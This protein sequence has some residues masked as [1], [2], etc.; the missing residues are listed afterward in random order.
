MRTKLREGF[1]RVKASNGVC[2]SDYAMNRNGKIY[3]ISTNEDMTI[4]YNNSHW[5]G[6]I[7]LRDTFGIRT[8][9]NIAQLLSFTFGITKDETLA[10]C[11]V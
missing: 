10:A 5:S 11:L 9:Y 7:K 1:R 6:N 8:K 3:K 2:Y 4:D